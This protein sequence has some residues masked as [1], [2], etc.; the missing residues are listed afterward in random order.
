MRAVRTEKVSVSFEKDDLKALRARAKRLHQGNLSKTL[1]DLVRLARLQEGRE[2]LLEW[3]HEAGRPTQ[4]E[5]DAVAM[6]WDAPL[7]PVKKP[8][9]RAQ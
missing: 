2:S 5:L 8:R 1:A 9:A 6:E 4:D 7:R 3:L